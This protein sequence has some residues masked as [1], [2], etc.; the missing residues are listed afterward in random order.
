[1][2]KLYMFWFQAKLNKTVLL[3]T[4]I[5]VDIKRGP[6][7]YNYRINSVYLSFNN[8][9]HVQACRVKVNKQQ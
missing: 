8:F 7:P 2:N 3:L 4:F 1:M 5:P 9:K 6:K